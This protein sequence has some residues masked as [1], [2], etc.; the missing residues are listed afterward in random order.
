MTKIYLFLFDTVTWLDHYQDSTWLAWGEPLTWLDL[1]IIRTRL[2][3]LEVSHWLDLTWPLS[4]LDL[5]CLRWATDLTWLAWFV[6]TVT[7]DLLDLFVLWLETC[8]RLDGRDLRLAWDLNMCDLPPPL[9]LDLWKSTTSWVGTI[10]GANFYPE[11]YLEPGSCGGNTPS[12]GP[13]SLVIGES[14]C[15]GNEAKV[16]LH[17]VTTILKQY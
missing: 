14:S 8:L 5:T 15:G 2:D 6:C 10:W 3:L 1:T 7:W 11:L 13:K 9:V 16:S 4:G 17:I 12:T